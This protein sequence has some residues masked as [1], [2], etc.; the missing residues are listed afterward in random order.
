V[1]YISLVNMNLLPIMKAGKCTAHASV[2]L[3]KYTFKKSNNF[4]DLNLL[5]N[6]IR[7][8]VKLKT[9]PNIDMQ[10]AVMKEMSVK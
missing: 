2:L 7:I 3:I 9:M 6:R 4:I 8:A 1:P 5:S 10:V